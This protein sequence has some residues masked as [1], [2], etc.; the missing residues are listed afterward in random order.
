[1]KNTWKLAP[2]FVLAVVMVGCGGGGGTPDP[3]DIGHSAFKKI[4]SKD[5][6]SLHNLMDT[7]GGEMSDEAKRRD[8][9]IAEGYD[10]WKE[11]KARLE[12][13]NGLDPKSKSEIDGEDKWKSMSPGKELGLEWGLY[14]LYAVDDLDKRLEGP[15]SWSA[16]QRLSIEGQGNASMTFTNGYNDTISVTMSR[17]EGLW[18]LTSVSTNFPKELPKK[19]KDD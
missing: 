13:D 15:W 10:R 11:Y 12:G 5:F 6:D 9:R 18:Y 2:L 14:K 8:W 4:T 16:D 1:M 7:W 19:P 17:R 3:R